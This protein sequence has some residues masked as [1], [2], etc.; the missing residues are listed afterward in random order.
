MTILVVLSILAAVAPNGRAAPTPSAPMPRNIKYE[1]V[2]GALDDPLFLTHAGDAS[3]RLFIVQRGGHIRI[4]KNGI[5]LPLPFL[6][7]SGALALDGGEQGLL[8]LAFDPNYETNGRF[9]IAYT[10]ASYAV[11]LAR[12]TVSADPD[13]AN[14][15]GEVLLSVPKTFTNHNGGMIAFGPDGYLYMGVGDGGSGGDPANNGQDRTTLLGKI[16]RLDVS[17]A[18]GYA[19]PSTNPYF[20]NPNPNVKK[21]VWAYGLRNPWR[22]SFDRGTGDLYIG[23]V[24]QNAQEEVDFQLASASGGQNYGWR[25]MEGNL[26]YYAITCTPPANYA[27]P[28]AVYDHGENDSNGCSVTGGYVYRGSN[29]PDLA[30]V[31][32]YADFCLGKIWG[33]KQNASNQWVTS[34]LADTH[35][36]ISSFGEDEQ[37]ELYLLDYGNGVLY[38]LAEAPRLTATY[39]SVGAHDGIILEVS[40][41]AGIG[42]SINATQLVL[43]VGDHQTDRQY[44]SILS[45]DTSTLP[46]DAQVTSVTLR[47]KRQKFIGDD[48][49]LTLNRLVADLGAPFFGSSADLEPVDFH[50]SRGSVAGTFNPTPVNSWYSL[51]F[52]FPSLT[53]LNRT[54]LTQLRLR[55]FL[56]DNDDLARDTL[57]FFSGDHLNASVRPVLIVEY[58]VP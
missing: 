22:F 54:G 15:T 33:L 14:A 57:Q 51:K 46:D 18:S 19:I 23:D 47:I 13:I 21:E 38:R 35:F 11:T 58:F 41:N 40:E 34:L 53:K 3:N 32:L 55:F 4:H 56:D 50:S 12:Y 10:A 39:T 9:Y 37:G 20:N 30:G 48:P 24:G 6:D 7:V 29:F 8:G 43:A 2:V 49:F 28:V 17:G 5:L 1:W 42:G 27:P 52:I 31:Y 16:L 36:L 44:R 25:V 26:C 45:F